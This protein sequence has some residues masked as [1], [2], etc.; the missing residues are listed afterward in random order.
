MKLFIQKLFIP[1]YWIHFVCR[2]TILQI[3]SSTIAFSILSMCGAQE[4]EITF[5]LDIGDIQNIEKVS[6]LG[7]TEPLSWERDFK[8]Q[9]SNVDNIYETKIRFNT[10][11]SNL[12]FRFKVNDEIELDGSDSRVI[13][14]K[15]L[16]T[17]KEYI[18]NEFQ[19]Y[20][21]R[22][23]EEI[24]FT[25]EQIEEDISI[26][27][28]IVQYVHPSIYAFRDSISLQDDFKILANE[29]KND[30]SLTNAYGCISKFAAK[31]KCSHTF[32]NPWNQGPTIEKALF[33]QPDKLP[34]TFNRIG[35]NLY[36]DK[37]ASENKRL[38][39]GLSII[40]ING[41]GTEDVL[42]R[43]AGYVTSDG[44]NYEKKL[45]RLTLTGSEKFALFDIFYPIEFGKTET[46]E[47]VLRDLNTNEE[48][49][50]SVKS[51]SKTN[52]TKVL[53]ERYD[54]ITISLRDGWNFEILDKSTAIL[55]ISSF[56]VHR[57]EFDWK[58]FLDNVFSRLNQQ[59]VENFIIDIRGNE[60]GQGEVGEYILKRLV[61]KPFTIMGTESSVSYLN[62]PDDFKKYMNTW[63]K[64]PYDFQTKI[65]G[66]KAGKY[67]LKKKYTLKS[68]TYKPLKSS[69]TGSVYLLT[70]ASNSSATHIMA[71]YAQQM[72]NVTIVGQETGG[73]QLGIN[74]SFMFFLRLPN[75]KV[76][77][78]IPVVHMVIPTGKPLV[79]GGV[80]PDV[81][82]DKNPMD[83]VN[84][85]D[86]ELNKVLELI[87]TK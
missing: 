23:I 7:N 10:S 17:A 41:I 39:K 70:D 38:K 5:R 34:F 50:T 28:K 4:R 15:D 12:K 32:T 63:D 2:K 86:T 83:F 85:L 3:I 24:K 20:N 59:S 52:R 18:F 13:W 30:P 81:L 56:A 77:L 69:F 35:K 8:L 53:M 66:Q 57:N 46:F 19:F 82:V 76:E 37:N 64:F 65:S 51:T 48:F 27:K 33:H 22:E 43:L 67:L 74:G 31:I 60:G 78:D 71:T 45:E 26:L 36:I 87:K 61:Q 1:Y 55:S 16:P 80:V 72:D 14:F 42:E 73:N 6:I 75:T 40:S 21:S 29:L 62:I 54:N 58:D 49:E 44:N 25:N 9:K 79:D 68:K 84:N 47:L 11:N